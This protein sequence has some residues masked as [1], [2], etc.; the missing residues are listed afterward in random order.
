MK[1]ELNFLSF[2]LFFCGDTLA[3]LSTGAWIGIAIGVIAAIAIIGGGAYWYFVVR[4]RTQYDE[5]GSV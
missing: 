1:N 2:F 5:I 4:P 3:G